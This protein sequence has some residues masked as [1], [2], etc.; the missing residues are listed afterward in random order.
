MSEQ[1]TMDE[2]PQIVICQGPPCCDLED[3]EAV[4]AQEAGCP[5]CERHTLL[6]CGKWVIDKPARA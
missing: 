3:D 1:L 2:A 5:W 4:A 6:P